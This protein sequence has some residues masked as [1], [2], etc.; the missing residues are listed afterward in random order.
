MGLKVI[1]ME[2][3][4]GDPLKHQLFNERVENGLIGVNGVESG[5]GTFFLLVMKTKNFSCGCCSAESALAIVLQVT[6]S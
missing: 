4:R 1:D 2:L 5:G 6:P 3:V